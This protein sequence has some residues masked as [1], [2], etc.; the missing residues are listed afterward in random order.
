[1]RTYPTIKEAFKNG[2]GDVFFEHLDGS[3]I[4]ISRHDEE[5]LDLYFNSPN[6]RFLSHCEIMELTKDER[7]PTTTPPPTPAHKPAKKTTRFYGWIDCDFYYEQY[8][9]AD[10]GL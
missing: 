1:M 4:C 5:T 8:S 2:T 3:F 9:D 7:K 10:P 6:F